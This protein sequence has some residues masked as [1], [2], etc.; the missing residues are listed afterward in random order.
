MRRTN[1]ALVGCFLCALATLSPRPA[2]ADD[3]PDATALSAKAGVLYD[4]GRALLKASKWE[5]ARASLLAAWSLHKHWQIAA[6]LATCEL[7]LGLAR[8]AAEHARFYLR[9]TL[10]DRRE[11][12]EALLKTASAKIA[13]LTVK[14]EPAGAEVLID[15]AT[16]GRAPLADALF[17]EPGRRHVVARS[18]GMPDATETLDLF[19]GSTRSVSL[20]LK[21]PGDVGGG[22]ASPP[23]GDGSSA[24]SASSSAPSA[25]WM[26]VTGGLAVVGLGFGIGFTVAANSK[27]DNA[28]DLQ[29]PGGESACFG[30]SPPP[31]CAD[32]SGVL[33]EQST[34]S[35]AALVSFL[36]GGVFTL[37]TAGLALWTTTTSSPKSGMRAVPTIS[38][39]HGGV[40]ILGTW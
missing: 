10:P 9:N 7:E 27:A 22:A 29:Q 40:T 20:E 19:A 38:A 30:S 23:V 16:V 33:K 1:R 15:G 35:D 3:P 25:G 39:T 12:A 18:P 31:G 2:R 24:P 4:E 32:L 37:G 6:S 17:V 13:T 8:E 36:L 21:R 11:R 34:L 28:V 14:V 26:A 5:D